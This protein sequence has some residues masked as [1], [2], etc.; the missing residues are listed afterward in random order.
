M[1]NKNFATKR[2]KEGKSKKESNKKKWSKEK[3]YAKG[4]RKLFKL[5]IKVDFHFE[6]KKVRKVQTNHNQHLIT[7]NAHHVAM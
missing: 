1:E 2:R 3:E 4:D 7:S 6:K 5:K